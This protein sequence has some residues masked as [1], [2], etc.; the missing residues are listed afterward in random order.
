MRKVFNV[1]CSNL[2]PSERLVLMDGLNVMMPRI[3]NGDS[4]RFV[5]EATSKPTI[6]L[7]WDFLL[8][9]PS[10]YPCTIRALAILATHRLSLSAKVKTSSLGYEI[11]QSPCDVIIYI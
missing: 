11:R 7:G 10:V 4:I 5:L 1:A 3:H 2:W 8:D 6:T 9:Y